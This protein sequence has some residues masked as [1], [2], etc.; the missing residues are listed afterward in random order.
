MPL[1]RHS[2]RIFLHKNCALIDLTGVLSAKENTNG[3]GRCGRTFGFLVT[4][5]SH[6]F[7]RLDVFLFWGS[8]APISRAVDP[9]SAMPPLGDLNRRS[10]TA[11]NSMELSREQARRAQ[12]AALVLELWDAVGRDR[13]SEYLQPIP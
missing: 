2:D 9:M 10:L 1:S 7:L 5:E 6:R 8:R 11:T 13:L 12:V 4:P 3:T